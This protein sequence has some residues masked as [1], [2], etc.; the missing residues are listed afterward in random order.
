[1]EKH[2]RSL[3]LEIDDVVVNLKHDLKAVECIAQLADFG[4]PAQKTISLELL[5]PLLDNITRNMSKNLE[6][7]SVLVNDNIR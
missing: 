5:V 3:L 2:N 1:M 7:I 4:V 6:V